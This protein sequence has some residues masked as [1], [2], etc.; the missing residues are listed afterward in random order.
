[1]S[2]EQ[3]AGLDRALETIR[4]FDKDCDG[5]LDV[6]E[7]QQLFL[8]LDKWWSAD[9]VEK[10][11][12]AA[13]AN[14]DG[15]VD[16]NELM[17]WLYQDGTLQNSIRRRN[18][19]EG[20]RS[21]LEYGNTAGRY[22]SKTFSWTFF[23]KWSEPWVADCIQKVVVRLHPTFHDPV[24]T[25][26]TAPF[27]LHQRGWGVFPLEVEVHWVIDHEP[28]SLAWMLQ[29]DAPEAHRRQYL[30]TLVW[31]HAKGAAG[32]NEINSEQGSEAVAEL[33]ELIAVGGP[34]ATCG[35]LKNIGVECLGPNGESPCFC[36]MDLSHDYRVYGC[37]KCM[38]GLTSAQCK[39]A[40]CKK[41]TCWGGCQ[42]RGR[43]GLVDPELGDESYFSD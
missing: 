22:D 4:S 7:L 40:G 33:G 14:H 35:G 41:H 9:K 2:E 1:M 24:R 26:Y 29:F 15:V 39:N 12:Q 17:S 23:V 30:P 20:I 6:S 31:R 11:V 16:V 38:S 43:R 42:S 21:H 25:L 13:D 37:T 36:G 18:V 5:I 32:A 28:T 3:I 10:L 27:E 34:C 8:K 19:L